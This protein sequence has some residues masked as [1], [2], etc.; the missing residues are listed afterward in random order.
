MLTRGDEAAVASD[1]V[2]PDWAAASDPVDPDWAVASDPVD[3]D[4]AV[5]S[6]PVDPSD[7]GERYLPF[8]QRLTAI[9]T[10]PTAY[11][12]ASIFPKLMA[13]FRKFFK[14]SCAHTS[15]HQIQNVPVH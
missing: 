12:P 8:T 4:W 1:P 3:P 11:V 13:T 5:A 2:D 6:D 7:P 14:S 10:P 15:A 9:A